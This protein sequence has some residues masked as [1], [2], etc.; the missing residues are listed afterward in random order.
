MTSSEALKLVSV[1]KAAYP[2]Q[3]M[4]EDTI[5]VYVSF[6]SDLNYREADQ[7]VRG[8]ITTSRFFPTIA[9]IREQVAEAYVE[10][11]SVA[12]AVAMVANR[13]RLSDAEVDANP[14][15]AEVLKAY[16]TVGG[17]WAF[18]TS[19]NPTTLHAQFR[20][21]YAQMRADKI[22]SHQHGALG[23]GRKVAELA[24]VNSNG[25]GK[26][27]ELRHEPGSLPMLPEGAQF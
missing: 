22:R 6:L 11:P 25:R 13:Y 8:V 1:L 19:T 10:L 27:E 2:R 26:D 3:E 16:R 14:L 4:G 20:D 15:P 5:E 17:E 21:L 23:V 12:E 9:E 24:A 7:A 18:R